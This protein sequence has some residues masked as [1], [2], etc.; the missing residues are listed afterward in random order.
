[1]G[2]FW[3]NIIS[4][5]A[6]G[7]RGPD[8]VPTA[9]DWSDWAGIMV[10]THFGLVSGL[11]WATRDPKR[12]FLASKRPQNDVFGRF[13]QLDGSKLSCNCLKSSE[14][15][16]ATIWTPHMPIFRSKQ[17]PTKNGPLLK[18]LG[19]KK[20]LLG[21]GGWKRDPICAIKHIYLTNQHKSSGLGSLDLLG[22][23]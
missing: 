11:F 22:S 15:S 21:P 8:L 13:L 20:R 18:G 6:E 17:H 9:T 5:F 19:P 4:D 14:N 12:A 10:T 2:T 1:M 7:H 3:K 16:V 23:L